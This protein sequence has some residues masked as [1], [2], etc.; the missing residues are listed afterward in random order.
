MSLIPPITEPMGRHWNQPDTAKIL[1]DEKHAVMSAATLR[2]LADYSCTQPSGVY[3]GKAWRSRKVYED[4]SKGWLLCWYDFSERGA[5]WCKTQVR[6][7][8]LLEEAA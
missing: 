1:L 7:I 3:V 4:D 8:L 2:Q 6:E 5:G